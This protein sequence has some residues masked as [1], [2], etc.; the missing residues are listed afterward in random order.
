MK[1]KGSNRLERELTKE[2]A[3][4][5]KDAEETTTQN[6]SSGNVKVIYKPVFYKV[7]DLQN[8]QIRKGVTQNIGVN[9]NNYLSKVNTFYMNIDGQQFIESARNEIYVIFKVQG[10]KITNVM[11][12]YHISNQ[13]NEYISSGNYQVI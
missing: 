7:Q 10:N 2:E 9:L 5:K 1:P 4:A 3:K 8:I 13:D 6:I 12:S 11:G